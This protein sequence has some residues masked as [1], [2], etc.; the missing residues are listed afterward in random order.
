MEPTFTVVA[1]FATRT[2][3]LRP[4]DTITADEFDGQMAIEDALRLK[5]IERP[6]AEKPAR[7]AAPVEQAD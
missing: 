4:G 3:R 7:P 2:R 5:L 6:A 1:A